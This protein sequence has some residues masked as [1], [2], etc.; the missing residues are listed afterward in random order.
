M[1]SPVL[2]EAEIPADFLRF[3]CNRF[4]EQKNHEDTQQN[5]GGKIYRNYNHKL[6]DNNYIACLLLLTPHPRGTTLSPEDCFPLSLTAHTLSISASRLQRIQ[7][8]EFWSSSQASAGH[9]LAVGGTSILLKN[10]C[11]RQALKIDTT[12]HRGIHAQHSDFGSLMLLTGIPTALEG[13][14]SPVQ[15]QETEQ[16]FLKFPIPHSAHFSEHHFQVLLSRLTAQR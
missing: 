4:S 10:I 3:R 16:V 11:S 5:S 12:Q 2:H 6:E 14:H 8:Q 9:L 1:V 15:R 7:Q 13:D